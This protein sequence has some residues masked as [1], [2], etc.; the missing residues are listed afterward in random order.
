MRLKLYLSTTTCWSK[1]GFYATKKHFCKS[2]LVLGLE[3]LFFDTSKARL[4]YLL[5]LLACCCALQW[6]I[7]WLVK[8]LSSLLFTLRNYEWQSGVEHFALFFISLFAIAALECMCIVFLFAIPCSLVNI[9]QNVYQIDHFTGLW[10]VTVHL[11]GIEVW[12]DLL[13]FCSKA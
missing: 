11:H 7:A 13:R 4:W 8:V 6:V 2:N 9:T 3:S 1:N 12:V 10:N 5:Q